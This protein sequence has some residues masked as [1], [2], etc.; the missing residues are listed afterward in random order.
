M[1]GDNYEADIL[2]ARQLGINTIWVTR[3]LLFPSS[4]PRIQEEKV[5]SNLSE[6]PALLSTQ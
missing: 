3:R 5:V 6:I 1:V 4:D 2:G